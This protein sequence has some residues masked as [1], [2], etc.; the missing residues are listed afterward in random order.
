MNEILKFKLEEACEIWQNFCSLHSNLFD[1]TCDEYEL[2][3]SSQIEDLE[4]TLTKKD[5]LINDIKDLENKR[6]SLID[7]IN[8][9]LPENQK[10]K[11]A[12][13]LIKIAGSDSRLEKFNLLLI[14]IIEK[15]QTQNKKNQ[16]FL[17]KAIISLQEIKDSFK[18]EKS[19]KTY[20]ANGYTSKSISR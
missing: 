16:L 19:Y 11:S 9:L 3:L 10:I 14:D 7:E 5:I 18:G 8:N 6:I 1:L 17:N 20:G 2:L 4:K 12:S 13:Q 15:I